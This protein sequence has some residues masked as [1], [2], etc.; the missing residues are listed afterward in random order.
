MFPTFAPKAIGMIGKKLPPATLG[1]CISIELRRRLTN[2]TIER[3]AHHDDDELGD[4]RRRLRRWSM[5]HADALKVE[6]SMPDNFDN[7]RA[8]Y[9][10][11]LRG[12]SVR[13][14]SVGAPRRSSQ[15]RLRSALGRMEP[16]PWS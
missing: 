11:P 14:L 1:R 5:D 8:A 12:R 7:R 3:F 4:L 6:V 13:I 15:A 2:E 16:W 10:A 9:P